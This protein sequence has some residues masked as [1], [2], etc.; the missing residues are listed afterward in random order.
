MTI[1]E[2][3][4]SRQHTTVFALVLERLRYWY[5]LHTSDGLTQS[6]ISCAKQQKGDLTLSLLMLMVLC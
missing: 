4:V 6:A 5:R 2:R 3:A 1:S